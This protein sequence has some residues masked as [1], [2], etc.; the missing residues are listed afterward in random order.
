MRSVLAAGIALVVCAGCGDSSD[1]PEPVE[2]NIA[3]VAVL[4]APLRVQA[5]A[6]VLLDGSGSSDEDGEIEANL[7]Q[8]KALLHPDD[9]AMAF[10]RVQAHFDGKASFDVE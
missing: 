6:P 8:F 5:G 10:D 7:A 4:S 9:V 1:T 3:P 2:D